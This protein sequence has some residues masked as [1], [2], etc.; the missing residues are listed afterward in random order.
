[1]HSVIRAAEQERPHEFRARL[2]YV[3]DVLKQFMEISGDD[4]LG[5][6][7]AAGVR[8]RINFFGFAMRLGYPIDIP[9]D[10]GERLLLFSQA[11]G[12]VGLPFGVE[13]TIA[14]REEEA[15]LDAIDEAERQER[16]A[17]ADRARK[18]RRSRRIYNALRLIF[19][20]YS[21]EFIIGPNDR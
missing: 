18:D 13:K 6:T 21:G 17:A 14:L 5:V 10:F 1:M 16:Q 9:D 4:A 11:A 2:E 12:I 7:G 15:W 8:N 20:V 19:R 3:C